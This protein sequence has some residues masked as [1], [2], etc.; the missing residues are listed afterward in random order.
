MAY[1]LLI[2]Q[3]V[4]HKHAPKPGCL[5]RVLCLLKD[6]QHHQL[7]VRPLGEDDLE[8]VLGVIQLGLKAGAV[9]GADRDAPH[10]RDLLG[11]GGRLGLSS[12][13]LLGPGLDGLLSG[14]QVGLP[15]A[16]APPGR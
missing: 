8:F 5:H 10:D 3:L 12:P 7:H 6:V 1:R 11:L 4:A 9:G 13:Q 2:Q 14:S 15:L 16:I